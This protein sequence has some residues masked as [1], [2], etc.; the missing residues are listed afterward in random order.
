MAAHKEHSGQLF[1]GGHYDEMLVVFI[2]LRGA[3]K[4]LQGVLARE[5]L[6]M[7]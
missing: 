2:G 6:L 4:R 7:G 5:V 1:I 3:R